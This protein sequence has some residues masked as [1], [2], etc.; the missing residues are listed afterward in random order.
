[1]LVAASPIRTRRS[2]RQRAGRADLWHKA[3]RAI[4]LEDGALLLVTRHRGGV[5]ETT[6]LVETVI[7]EPNRSAPAQAGIAMLAALTELVADKHCHS[8][9]TFNVLWAIDG[10]S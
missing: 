9:R 1:M 4:D 8:N 7:T 10:Q 5:C 3:E 6:S 2:G